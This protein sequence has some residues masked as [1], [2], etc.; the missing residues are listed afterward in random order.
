MTTSQASD[1]PGEEQLVDL[2]SLHEDPANARLHG[3]RNLRAITASLQHWGQVENLVVQKGTG[4]VIGGNG[5]LQAMRALGWKKASAKLI[6]VDATQA[7]ALGLALNRTAEL[8]DWDANAL[9]S[10]TESLKDADVD[11]ESLSLDADV[12]TRHLDELVA[13]NE[14]DEESH[15]ERNNLDTKELDENVIPLPGTPVTAVGDIW[16]LGDHKLMCADSSDGQAMAHLFGGIKADMIFTDPPYNLAEKTKGFAADIRSTMKNLMESSWDKGFDFSSHAA[17]M[18]N[19]LS[20]DASVYICTSH[21]IS[22]VIWLWMNTWAKFCNYCIWQKKN[23]MP[24]LSKRHYTWCTEIICY[25]TRGKH[26]FNFPKEGHALSVWLQSSV[27]KCDFH[28]TMKPV[29]IPQHAISHSSNK[30]DI[31]ADF[32]A[33]AGS[34]L[35]ACETLNRRAICCEIDP[36]YCDVIVQ[37]WEDLTGRKA[38]RQ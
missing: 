38:T 6:D 9:K 29:S 5:R 26:T 21:F 34:T 22:P 14:Q 8:A 32:F 30:G 15:A 19:N 18:L 33:G 37:R 12:I 35:L 3:E 23:P 11:L 2:D 4:K 13:Q 20:E 10:L 25:A 17:S 36:K 16:I 31:V 27:A 24:S 7:T 1:L 28:P